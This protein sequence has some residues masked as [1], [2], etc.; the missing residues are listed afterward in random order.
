MTDAEIFHRHM[1]PYGG[2][3]D[4]RIPAGTP[5][6][7]LYTKIEEAACG[8]IS[9]ARS[10]VPRLPEIHFDFIHNGIINA[11]AFKSEGRYFIG[12]TTGAL[13]ML[14]LAFSSMLA[15]RSLFP[16]YGNAKDEADDLPPLKDYVPHAQ[17]M[18]DAGLRPVLPR[19]YPRFLCSGYFLFE[20]FLFLIGHEIAHIARGH[21]D[22]WEAKVGVPFVAELTSD[23]S[24]PTLEIERQAIEV[25]ADTRSIFAAAASLELTSRNADQF[26]H[27]WASAPPNLETLIWDWAFALHTLFRLFGDIQFRPEELAANTYPPLPVRRAIARATAYTAFALRDS[28]PTRKQM[29]LRARNRSRRIL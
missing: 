22:Y 27:P 5:A 6:E 25:D 4:R 18:R 3:L 2:R 17:K 23:G 13:Y 8:L 24:A 11:Y 19:T 28:E 14:Q 16:A 7:S 9:S 1:Q 10:Y 29:V 15:D 26:Q 21:V 20:A 12:I